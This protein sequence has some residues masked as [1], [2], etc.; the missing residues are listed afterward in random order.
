MVGYAC[1]ET[2]HDAAAGCAGSPA[3]QCLTSPGNP[4]WVRG[5]ARTGKP[6]SPWNTMR[7]GIPCGWTRLF[8]PP[9]TALKKSSDELYWELTDKVIAPAFA[10]P[11]PRMR[12]RKFSR[13]LPGGLFWAARKPTPASPGESSW[14]TAT[15]CS[16]PHGGAHSSGKDPTKV[17]RSGAYMARYIAKNL[18]AAGLVRKMSGH[19]GLRYWKSRSRSWWR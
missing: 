15:A 18:V 11:C 5:F 12:I 3:H 16:P 14:W 17:D 2:P 9:S 7:M 13:T 19:A 10:G 8:F 6:R 1:S 4:A